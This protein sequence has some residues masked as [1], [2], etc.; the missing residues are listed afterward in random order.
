MSEPSADPTPE[1]PAAEEPAADEPE[2]FVNRAARRAKGKKSSAPE[3]F[4]KGQRPGGRGAV[5]AP[6]QYGTRRSG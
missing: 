4:D 6:R 2:V 1:E 3:V 5:Q